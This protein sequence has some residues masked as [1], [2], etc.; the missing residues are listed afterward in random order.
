MYRGVLCW[1]FCMALCLYCGVVG[2]CG[3]CGVYGSLH[4]PGRDIIDAHGL[5]DRRLGCFA[6]LNWIDVRYYC[7]LITGGMNRQLVSYFVLYLMRY[8]ET[9]GF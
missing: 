5:R 9:R 8:I 2:I 3:I 6:G 1:V 7:S 4:F